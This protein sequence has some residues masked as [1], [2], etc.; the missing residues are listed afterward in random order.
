MTKQFQVKVNLIQ[1]CSIAYVYAVVV[2]FSCFSAYAF[3]TSQNAITSAF[4]KSKGKYFITNDRLSSGNDVLGVESVMS[5][6]GDKSCSRLCYIGVTTTTSLLSSL[7]QEDAKKNKIS[8]VTQRKKEEIITWLES[9]L[10]KHPEDQLCM[11]GDVGAI[12]VYTFLDH[13]INGYYDSLLNSPDQLAST[14]HDFL[15]SANH[16]TASMV[17]SSFLAESSPSG[18]PVWFDTMNS[19]PFGI[20]PF[21]SSLP[22]VHHITYAPVISTSGMAFFL[23]ASTWIFCGYFTGAFLFENTLEC[24]VTHA[25]SKTAQTWAFTCA[26]MVALA[27]ESDSIVGCVDCL[28]KSVGLTKADSDFIFDSL[29]VLLMWRFTISSLLGSGRDDT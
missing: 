12:F 1:F 23:L 5:F 15:T 19:A 10:P 18:V 7:D 28:H 22:I 16:A 3:Q 9:I 2:L 17:E 11:S 27:Y 21:S 25:I 14:A 13:S 24:S 8:E 4:Y 29:S 20:I 26:I 6:R